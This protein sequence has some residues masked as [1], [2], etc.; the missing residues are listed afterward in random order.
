MKVI[1]ALL[2][3]IFFSAVSVTPG[4][5]QSRP[6]CSSAASD[7][8]GDGYGW[9]NDATCLVVAQPSQ[10]ED[11]GGFPWGWDPATLTSCRLDEQPGECL[12]TDGDGWGWDGF[13][14]CT[15]NQTPPMPVACFDSD[16]DGFG[17]NGVETCIVNTNF[18]AR[19]FDGQWPVCE[20][21][22]AELGSSP[23]VET[24]NPQTGFS[25]YCVKKC[26]AIGAVVDP[27]YPGWGTFNDQRCFITPQDSTP[28]V[29]VPIYEP[30]RL[31]FYTD[32]NLAHLFN[33][34]RA[35]ACTEEIR[36]TMSGSFT[37]TQNSDFPREIAFFRGNMPFLDDNGIWNYTGS[38]RGDGRTFSMW[39]L[40]GKSFTT[41]TWTSNSNVEPIT[42]T[43]YL[44]GNRRLVCEDTRRLPQ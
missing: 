42:M 22:L 38:W 18:I 37:E 27:A 26:P 1:S 43:F 8:D 14:S 6:V 25:T 5:A 3:T 35:A 23:W 17:W 28:Q 15:I 41:S 31:R 34:E 33:F 24:T 9:E 19:E 32:V 40:N 36:D 13:Q 12:D 4:F 20:S 16:G 7:S 29:L 10:C 21:S 2:S 39:D 11:R 30:A 44:S